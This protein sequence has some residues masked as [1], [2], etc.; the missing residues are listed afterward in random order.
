MVI[1]FYIISEYH[2]QVET[3][4]IGLYKQFAT[5]GIFPMLFMTILFA[6][7]SKTLSREKQT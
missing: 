5:W 1:D 2:K 4:G 3:L 6:K 7:I